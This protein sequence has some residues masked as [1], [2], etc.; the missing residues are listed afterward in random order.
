[1]QALYSSTEFE[2]RFTYTGNDLG[3]THGGDTF[4]FRLWAPCASSVVLCVYK[5]GDYRHGLILD[6]DVDGETIVSSDESFKAA[7][8]RAY[9]ATGTCGYHTPAGDLFQR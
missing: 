3:L 7:T 1:M 8:H 4:H 6:L 9:T 2:N 5:S